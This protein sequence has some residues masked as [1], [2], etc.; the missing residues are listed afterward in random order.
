MTLALLVMIGPGKVMVQAVVGLG[1]AM[2]LQLSSNY[3]NSISI[4]NN[5]IVN[6]INICAT[7]SY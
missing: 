3:T 7:L 5:L 1:L 6:L 2:P 4:F